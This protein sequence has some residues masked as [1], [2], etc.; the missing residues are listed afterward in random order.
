MVVGEAPVEKGGGG[1]EAGDMS[2]LNKFKY[3]IACVILEFIE[4]FTNFSI[5]INMIS[6]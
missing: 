5:F 3:R 6:F 4:H 2:R 1:E